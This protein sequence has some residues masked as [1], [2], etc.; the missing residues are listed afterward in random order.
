MVIHRVDKAEPESLEKLKDDL[1]RMFD[2]TD[3]IILEIGPGISFDLSLV[4]L[5]YSAALY[6]KARKKGF[7]LQGDEVQ[8]LEKMQIFA[9]L[10]PLPGPPLAEGID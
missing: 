5:I 8:R 2:T 10:P 9:G 1:L 3:G 7:F 4:Q 6:A